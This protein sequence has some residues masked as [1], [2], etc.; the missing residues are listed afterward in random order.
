MK[1][2]TTVDF[3]NLQKVSMIFSLLGLLIGFYALTKQAR[4]YSRK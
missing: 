1:T 4:V 3:T 2:T